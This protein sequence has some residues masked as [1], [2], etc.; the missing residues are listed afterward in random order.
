MKGEYLVDLEEEWHK[1]LKGLRGSLP[2]FKCRIKPG[3]QGEGFVSFCEDGVLH[4]EAEGSLAASYACAQLSLAVKSGFLGEHL[5]L[6]QPIYP[7]RPLWIEGGQRVAV[8]DR[9]SISFPDCFDDAAFVSPRDSNVLNHFCWKLLQWGYNSVVFGRLDASCHATPQEKRDL[10]LLFLFLQQC[11]IKVFVCPT[12]SSQYD[13][14]CPV[15]GGC[16]SHVQADLSDLM[17]QTGSVDGLVWRSRAY[18][19]TFMAHP[20][21]EQETRYDLIVKEAAMVKAAVGE[22]AQ[23]L[24]FLP[25]PSYREGRKQA[26]VIPSLLDDVPENTIVV[27]SPVA[28]EFWED[29]ASWH[30]V[31]DALRRIPDTSGTP[32]MPLVNVGGK[33]FGECLWPSIPYDTLDFVAGSTKR[34]AFCGIA[35][36]AYSFPMEEGILDCALWTAGQLMWRDIPAVMLSTAWLVATWP[37]CDYLNIQKTFEEVRCIAI[38]IEALSCRAKEEAGDEGRQKTLVT[39]SALL[40]R[41]NL[42]KQA[43]PDTD[44]RVADQVRYFVRDG[45]RL[46]FDALQKAKLP[47]GNVLEGDDLKPAFWTEIRNV[48]ERGIGGSAEVVRL[49]R[50][51]DP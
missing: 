17:V 27:F 33:G 29:A 7:L 11:G 2:Q 1:L 38:A 26:K 47:L 23:L 22:K 10:R 48:T 6:Q 35:S 50:P 32:L 12:F 41:L 34:H 25:T 8:T 46:V 30:P 9:T 19:E 44:S 4:I 37:G 3:G 21:A 42:L 5:G 31:W 20:D 18:A 49:E 43:G 16:Y 51:N 24:Y 36:V 15:D 40:A 28:G 14:E 13:S 39:A 45:K